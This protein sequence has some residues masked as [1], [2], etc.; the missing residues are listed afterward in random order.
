M[1]KRLYLC[2]IKPI[3]LITIYSPIMKL[4]TLSIATVL[5][6]SF[7]ACSG[8][9]KDK[10][11]SEGAVAVYFPDDDEHQFI[12]DSLNADSLLALTD[13]GVAYKILAEGVGRHVTE[14]DDVLINYTGKLSDGTV[15]YTTEGKEPEQYPVKTLVSGFVEGIK[16][17]GR[18][19]KIHMIIPA[20]QAYKDKGY[21][22][23]GIYPGATL[24]FDVQVLDIK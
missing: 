16:M 15:F 2:A 5:A 22:D 1:T 24:V 12:L 6:L 20:E 13:S 19:G 8:S 11:E 23:A 9:S 18:G 4:I 10:Q 21:K 17:L 7:A 14:D 3:K